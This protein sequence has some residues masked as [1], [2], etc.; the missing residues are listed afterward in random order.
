MPQDIRKSKHR[1]IIE[2]EWARYKYLVLSHS[3]KNYLKI[4]GLLRDNEIIS[5]LD[6]YEII[7]QSLMITS[8][9]NDEINAAQHVWGYFK[10]SAMQAEKEKMSKLMADYTKGKI[11]I[12]SAKRF[13]QKLALK[14]NETYLKDNYYFIENY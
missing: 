3:H 9:Q 1:Q 6:F 12:N 5:A 10:K 4:R 8:T 13:L 7:D 11:G 14:Y 2:K